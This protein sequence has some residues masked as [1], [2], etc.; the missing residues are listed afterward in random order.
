MSMQLLLGHWLAL[1]AL[2]DPLCYTQA[3]L[4]QRFALVMLL[5][6]CSATGA[7]C[8]RRWGYA[9]WCRPVL[10]LVKSLRRAWLDFSRIPMIHCSHL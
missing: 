6:G 7:C 8:L 9:S 1:E 2:D 4:L 3:R 5:V 10:L